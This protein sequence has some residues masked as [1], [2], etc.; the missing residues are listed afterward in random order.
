MFVCFPDRSARAPRTVVMP[1]ASPGTPLIVADDCTVQ[2]DAKILEYQLFGCGLPCR[3]SQKRITD[4][5]PVPAP[6][7]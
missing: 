3:E 7:T 5:S 4:V 1:A 2:G 6:T